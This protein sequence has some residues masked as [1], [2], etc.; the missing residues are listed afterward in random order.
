MRAARV[1]PR[2]T[3]LKRESWVHGP[4]G[5]KFDFARGPHL[6]RFGAGVP[7]LLGQVPGRDPGDVHLRHRDV[8]L[9]RRRVLGRVELDDHLHGARSF[10]S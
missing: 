7:R 2:V 3:K 5:G 6:S 8:R 1:T 4:L 9:L 10:R